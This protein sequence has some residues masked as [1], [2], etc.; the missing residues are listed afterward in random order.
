MQIHGPHD[1]MCLK[2]CASVHLL[3][4]V[5]ECIGNLRASK[6][7]TQKESALPKLEAQDDSGCSPV[8]GAEGI[9]PSLKVLE[10]SVIPLDHAPM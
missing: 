6:G 1:T 7:A 8:A 10:T 9:E 2:E 4:T 3:E 5:K